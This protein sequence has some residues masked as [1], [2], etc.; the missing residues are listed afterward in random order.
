MDR[1]RPGCPRRLSLLFVSSGL[2]DAIIAAGCRS[3]RRSP[4]RSRAA[5]MATSRS[6]GWSAPYCCSTRSARAASRS[7]ARRLVARPGETAIREGNKARTVADVTVGHQVHVKGVWLP[8]E[9]SRQPVRG[10]FASFL[11][12]VQGGRGR[13]QLQAQWLQ[14]HRGG[15][16][17]QRQAGDQGPHERD[18]H[19]LRLVECRRPGQQGDGTEIAFFRPAWRGSCF[20]LLGTLRLAEAC[21]QEDD[22]P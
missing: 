12:R 3:G 6:R 15:V 10:G 19:E 14:G 22:R 4:C 11:L 21:P 13:R 8:A 2:R 17:G 7:T 1:H 5:A 16:R 9:A 20:I 18:A